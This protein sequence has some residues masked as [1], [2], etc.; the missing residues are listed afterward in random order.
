MDSR[1]SLR[2]PR[3]DEDVR[4]VKRKKAGIAPGLW[5]FAVM[6]GLV[7]GIHVLDTMKSWMA[8][9]SPAMTM[10]RDHALA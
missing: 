3:N 5:F 2:S 10:V 4:R 1:L 9:S 7:P 8:G 6:P